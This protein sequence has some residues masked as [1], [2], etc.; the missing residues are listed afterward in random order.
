VFKNFTPIRFYF[1]DVEEFLKI[2][3]NQLEH[4]N[5]IDVLNTYFTFH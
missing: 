1:S 4:L 3:G 5:I 2:I